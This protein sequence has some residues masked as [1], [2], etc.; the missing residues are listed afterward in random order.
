MPARR[1]VGALLSGLASMGVL[2]GMLVVHAWPLWTGTPIYLDVRPV[3]PRSLFRGDYV[4]LAYAIDTLT[5]RVPLAG[6]SG[7]LP[8]P[9]NR[10]QVSVAPIG[11]WWRPADERGGS[12]LRRGQQLYLQL[13][14]ETTSVPGVPE[15]H[16]PVSISDRAIDGAVNLAGRVRH[17][18]A[19]YT[20][21]MD[22]GI[23]ALFVQEGKGKP[24][25]AA[26]R[27]GRPVHAAVSVASSGTARVRALIIDGQQ[28][29]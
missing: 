29:P 2:G 16:V 22:F 6:S 20:I 23:D 27:S 14:P 1:V 19:G 18:D 10:S 25:E 9:A 5:L 28:R 15:R 4:T 21:Q 12:R 3:D 17:A 26:L 24:I 11:D 8:M 7:E 13:Q